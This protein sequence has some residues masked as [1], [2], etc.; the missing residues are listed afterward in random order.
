MTGSALDNAH[1][2]SSSRPRRHHRLRPRRLDRRHLR[3]PRAA[4]ARGPLR[5]AAGRPAHHHHRRRELPG[6]PRGHPGPLADG[7]DAG[8]GRARGR[9]GR[10]RPRGQGR[11]VQAPLP[12]DLQLR[13]GVPGRD[14]DHRHR[15]PGQV[16]GPALASSASSGFGVSACATCDG[17][18]YRGKTVAVVGGGNTAVEEALFLTKF[19]AKVYLV[20]RRDELRA[21][22]ILQDRLFADPKIEVVWNAAIDEVLGDRGPARRH[23]RAAEG[24]ARPARRASSPSTA[25]SSPSATPRPRSCSWA[26]SR[27]SRAAI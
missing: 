25:S 19:A 10:A 1:V 20:H 17:F 9:R 4:E 7:R 18:F 14:G 3:R 26:S 12:P 23:R 2:R 16:A 21:E 11:P 8:P 24:P 27:P 13:R 5:P 15:R 22:R 6:L